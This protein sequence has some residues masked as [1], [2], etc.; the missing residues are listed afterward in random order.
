MK[1]KIGDIIYKYYYGQL[2]SKLVIDRLTKKHAFSGNYEFDIEYDN[3]YL[4]EAPRNVW[5]NNTYKIETP[6]IKN[7]WSTIVYREK[8]RKRI[9]SLS[10]EQLEKIFKII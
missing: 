8:L 5:S 1:L 9:D 2:N 3:G 4:M 6:E 10:L 7:E